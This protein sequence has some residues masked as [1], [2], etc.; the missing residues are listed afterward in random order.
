MVDLHGCGL[1]CQLQAGKIEHLPF[2]LC[3]RVVPVCVQLR[4]SCHLWR[5]HPCHDGFLR[6]LIRLAAPVISLC[7]PAFVFTIFAYL[8]SD[9]SKSVTS[10]IFVGVKAFHVAPVIHLRFWIGPVLMNSRCLEAVA[11]ASFDDGSRFSSCVQQDVRVQGFNARCLHD[12]G[13]SFC[14]CVA[15]VVSSSFCPFQ[16]CLDVALSGS[17]NS[18]DVAAQV[19]ISVASELLNCNFISCESS[20][21]AAVV[22]VLQ[23]CCCCCCCAASICYSSPAH[24]V[25]WCT[26]ADDAAWLVPF[27]VMLLVWERCAVAACCVAACCGQCSRSKPLPCKW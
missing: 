7:F 23:A 22:A 13:V 15:C 4:V 11:P 3:V 8:S 18:S 9:V 17:E 14:C 25:T 2:H 20:A 6:R 10:V 21:A 26:C 5:R 24:C 19:V 16:R 1:A 27:S 12:V